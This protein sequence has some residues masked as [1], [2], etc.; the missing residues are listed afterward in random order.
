MGAKV[1][2]HTDHA[3]LKYLFQKKESKPRLIRWVLL[4]QEFDLEL[5]GTKGSKN[6]V[7]DHLSRLTTQEINVELPPI[8]ENFPDEHL[9]HAQASTSPWYADYVNYIVAQVLA[10]D[11]DYHQKMRF[12]NIVKQY[13]RKEPYLFKMCNDQ[14]RRR[15]VAEEE[16]PDIL[17]HC[18]SS[19]YRGHFGSHRTAMKVL[20]SGFY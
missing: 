17:Y 15:C 18:H 1:I 11:L 19:N 12:L 2:V 9:F 20:Q 5:G 10:K 14:V 6:V 7:C 16:I 13:Y 8:E 4:L 3:A